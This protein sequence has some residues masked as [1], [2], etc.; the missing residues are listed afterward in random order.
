MASGTELVGGRIP[1]E[2]I[3]TAIET[4]DSST[5]TT[6]ETAIAQVAPDVV[7][8]RRY[9][10]WAIFRVAST[11]DNDDVQVLIR[12]DSTSGTVLTEDGVELTHDLQSTRG[13]GGLL[14]AEFTA[15][16]TET[17][18]F[19][20]SAVRAAGTGNIRREATP[21]KPTYLF[22]EYVSG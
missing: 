21:N 9:A 4:S 1:G 11:V 12:E 6:T 7:D 14:Y 19:V 5:F 8:G 18:T 17:K 16:A 22:V 13:M 2:R 3:A 20:L 10:V 15:T